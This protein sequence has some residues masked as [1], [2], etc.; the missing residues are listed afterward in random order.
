MMT[1]LPLA[2][3]SL[4]ISRPIPALPPVIKMVL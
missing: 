3:K 4:A 1:L 2:E